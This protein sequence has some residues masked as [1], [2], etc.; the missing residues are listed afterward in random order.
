MRIG[1]VGSGATG[2][3]IARQLAHGA[4]PPDL[5]LID[6]RPGVAAEVARSLGGTVAWSVGDQVPDACDVV[7]LAT[8]VGKHPA[9]ARAA[10]DHGSHVVSISDSIPDVR[11]LLRLD[12]R[13]RERERVV[14]VGAGM[15]PG[16]TDLLAA[17]AASWFDRLDEIHVSKFGTGGPECARQH[18]GALKGPCIDLRDDEWVR[19]AGGSG[20][21][22]AWF[23]APVHAADCYRAALVDPIL[24]SRAF[25]DVGR[26]SARMAATRRDRM[27]M[28]LP[29]LRR[30][31]PEG[32]LGAARVDLRGTRDGAVTDVV[33]GCSE[34]PAVAAGAVASV[35][36]NYAAAG[37]TRLGALGLAEG[38]PVVEFLHDL[39]H[40]GLRLE[41]FVGSGAQ[42]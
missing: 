27:T 13:A 35:A 33:L 40:R 11:G 6:H 28:H 29:M 34:R 21:E 2:R 19:R 22:L 42:Y 18:H 41:L 36:A 12:E 39:R 38:V 7:V 8:G 4:A 3:R 23:P 16:L 10:V 25:P 17:H 14:L 37:R 32:L 20:R 30:P 5:V 1:V 9:L 31:H 26:I 24:L 15:M